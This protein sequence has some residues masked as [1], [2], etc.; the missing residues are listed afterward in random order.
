M[1]I[2]YSIK[3]GGYCYHSVNVITFSV[4]TLSGFYCTLRFKYYA[5]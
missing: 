3:I 4:I 2:A 1:W 5:L